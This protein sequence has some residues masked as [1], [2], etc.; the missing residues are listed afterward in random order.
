VSDL[1]R[2]DF[3]WVTLRLRENVRPAQ[4]AGVPGVSDISQ[5]ED[6]LRLRLIGDFDPLLRRIGDFYVQDIEVQEPSLEEIFLTF[7]GNHGQNG[8]PEETAARVGVTA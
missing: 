4:L 5:T 8:Q 6:G 1:T 2:T 7:Y 3:H